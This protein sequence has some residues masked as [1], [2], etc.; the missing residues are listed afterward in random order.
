MRVLQSGLPPG[1]AQASGVVCR[2]ELGLCLNPLAYWQGLSLWWPRAL[3]TLL[4]LRVLNLGPPTSPP[5]PPSLSL[6]RQPGALELP[7]LSSHPVLPC[8][9]LLG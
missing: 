3:G 5:S 1:K 6:C 7:T 2:A 9:P 8:L 4:S